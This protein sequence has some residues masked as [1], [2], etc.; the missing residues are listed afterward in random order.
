MQERNYG[1]EQSDT[2]IRFILL[3]SQSRAKKTLKETC[4]INHTA[5]LLIPPDFSIAKQFL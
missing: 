5:L 4:I 1:E 2:R 3:L